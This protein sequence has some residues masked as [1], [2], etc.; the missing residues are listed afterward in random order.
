MNWIIN[1]LLSSYYSIVALR[2]RGFAYFRNVCN[3]IFVFCRLRPVRPTFISANHSK[4]RWR[5]DSI[6]VHR[7][8]GRQRSGF[9]PRKRLLIVAADAEQVLNCETL[10]QKEENVCGKWKNFLRHTDART[11]TQLR[12]MPF[13]SWNAFLRV[14]FLHGISKLRNEWF[15][16]IFVIPAISWDEKCDVAPPASRESRSW[17]SGF[18][19]KNKASSDETFPVW[20]RVTVARRRKGETS[21]SLLE[22]K[23]NRFSRRC[24]VN[25]NWMWMMKEIS[26]RI[27]YE[28][29]E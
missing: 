9:W 25:V 6:R 2:A 27:A 15:I 14:S 17:E 7:R 24:H 18:H 26:H 21:L 19:S 1:K 3:A 4:S 22:E 8:R 29:A 23:Q 12:E 16:S 11:P 28:E 5:K 13:H 20:K 10:V